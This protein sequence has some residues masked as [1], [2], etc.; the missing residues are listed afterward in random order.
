MRRVLSDTSSLERDPS[1]CFWV[2]AWCPECTAKVQVFRVP[3]RHLL[4]II[5]DSPSCQVTTP[6]Q[7]C[8]KESLRMHR[9]RTPVRIGTRMPRFLSPSATITQVGVGPRVS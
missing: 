3:E 5:T 6:F 1:V 4:C 2:D 9:R 7:F 8:H